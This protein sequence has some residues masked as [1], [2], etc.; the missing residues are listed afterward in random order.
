MAYWNATRRQHRST[1]IGCFCT[2]ETG[3]R[4][5]PSSHWPTEHQPMIPQAR[6]LS[7]WCSG[8][9]Y[10]CPVTCCLQFSIQHNTHQH[11]K[12]ANI[13]IKASYDHLANSTGVQEGDHVWLYYLTWT[14]RMPSKPQTSWEGPYKVVTWIN[15][16]AYVIQHHPQRR[17]WY[18]WTHWPVFIKY[19][20]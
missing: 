10:T 13:R 3:M 15:D 18:F 16:V 4:G 14:R 12:L 17:W 9:S 2:P 7:A 5:Y 8:G 19:L 20:R 6:H 11:L 1:W